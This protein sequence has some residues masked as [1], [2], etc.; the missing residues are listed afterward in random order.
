MAFKMLQRKQTNAPIAAP[1]VLLQLGWP[2]GNSLAH[3]ASSTTKKT[4]GAMNRR[5]KGSLN[6]IPE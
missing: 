1:A 6:P 3:V 4:F 5:P 2:F